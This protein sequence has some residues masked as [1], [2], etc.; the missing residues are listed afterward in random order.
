MSRKRLGYASL[1]VAIAGGAALSVYVFAVRPW[2][3][4]WGATDQ[5]VA[6]PCGSGWTWMSSRGIFRS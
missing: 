4:R 3:R 2:H 1:G 6:Q 5:E